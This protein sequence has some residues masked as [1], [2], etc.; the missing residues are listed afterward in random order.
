MR[1]RC[2]LNKRLLNI[3]SKSQKIELNAELE[4]IEDALI[5]SH[6]DE[7]KSNESKAIASIKGNSKYYYTYAKK[8]LHS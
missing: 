2:K 6:R 7:T 1:K 4:L 5:K 3:S 8:K